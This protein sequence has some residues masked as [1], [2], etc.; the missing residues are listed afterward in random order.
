VRTSSLDEKSTVFAFRC[1]VFAAL[2]LLLAYSSRR[3]GPIGFAPYCAAGFYLFTSVVLWRVRDARLNSPVAQGLAYLWDVG[4][5]TASVYCSEGFD[6]E[7]YLMYFLIMFMSGLMTQV[8]QSFLIGTVSSLMYAG[9]WFEGK[10]AVDLPLENLLLRFA[11][12]YIV[13]FF[14]AVMAHRVRAGDRRAKTLELRLALER[15][16]NGGWGLEVDESLDPEVKKTVLTLNA[17]LDN[18]SR[19]LEK[20]V[21]ENEDLRL[22]IAR[23]RER[24]AGESAAAPSGESEGPRA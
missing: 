8:G 9:L 13:A 7:L 2:V 19:A 22:A 5:V 24:R 17:L 20:M 14:T 18:L 15:L 6:N 1:L 4:I 16:A 11:F 12:F 21:S 10:T 23:A 3:D